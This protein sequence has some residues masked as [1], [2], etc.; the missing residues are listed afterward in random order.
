MNALDGWDRLIAELSDPELAIAD[1]RRK[2][3]ST[4]DFRAAIRR[5]DL[6]R[7]G[8]LDADGIARSHGER[9]YGHRSPTVVRMLSALDGGQ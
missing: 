4:E 6:V 8:V 5:D 1:G 3:R 9:T 7:A 2:A